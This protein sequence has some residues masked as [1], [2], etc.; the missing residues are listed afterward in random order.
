MKK[1]SS[2][3]GLILLF[4]SSYAQKFEKYCELVAT[5][6]LFSRKV[7]I[8]VD[9]GE[10]RKFFSFKDPRVKTDLGKIKNFNSV[11]DGINYMGTLGWKLV[12]AFPI[13]TTSGPMVYHFY[14]KKEFDL[15]E[16]DNNPA[17]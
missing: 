11:V 6:K 3:L 5:G 8:D 17:E 9:Y 12:D 16:L 7:S 14:F 4:S 2:T 10:E 15:S 13:S 1:L